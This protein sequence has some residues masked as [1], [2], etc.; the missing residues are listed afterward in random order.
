MGLFIFVS[1]SVQK[2][3]PK[4]PK[5]WVYIDSTFCSIEFNFYLYL[6]G[7]GKILYQYV[8]MH[9]DYENSLYK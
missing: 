3:E 7:T 2:L 4:V 5:I 8:S 6:L 9:D 1:S